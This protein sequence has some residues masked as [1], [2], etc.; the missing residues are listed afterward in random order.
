MKTLIW[1]K[2][3]SRFLPYG[4]SLPTGKG[5]QNGC[6]HTPRHKPLR[7]LPSEG[8]VARLWRSQVKPT[9]GFFDDLP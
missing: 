5:K 2:W 4:S 3:A 9:V 1:Q 6:L 7:A 8:E